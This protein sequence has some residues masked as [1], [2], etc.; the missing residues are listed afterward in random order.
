MTSAV[1][2]ALSICD[3]CPIFSSSVIRPRRSCTRS[4]MGCF[5]SL[6][7]TYC[8]ADGRRRTAR[9]TRHAAADDTVV[10]AVTATLVDSVG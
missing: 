5:A 1:A 6:Y 4:L 9:T 8:A 10:I 2:L 7:L 3:I